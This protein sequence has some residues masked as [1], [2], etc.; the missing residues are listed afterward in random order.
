MQRAA[1]VINTMLQH[2][3]ATQCLYQ[4]GKDSF[5]V[6]CSPFMGRVAGIKAWGTAL[7]RFWGVFFV[8]FLQILT[9]PSGD[10]LIGMLLY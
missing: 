6:F 7:I 5:S 10:E 1:V 8:F 9:K 3:V 4:C 2:L